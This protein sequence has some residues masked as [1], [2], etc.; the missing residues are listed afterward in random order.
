MAGSFMTEMLRVQECLVQIEAK[1]RLEEFFGSLLP[2]E[3]I[4]TARHRAPR[5]ARQAPER[6]CRSE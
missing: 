5:K 3:A 2:L 1:W 4:I 6:F